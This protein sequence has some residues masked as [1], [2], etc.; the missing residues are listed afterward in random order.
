MMGT[1]GLIGSFS[2]GNLS[3]GQS[4]F[5]ILQSLSRVVQMCQCSFDV[6]TKNGM[7]PNA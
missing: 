7:S 4:P 5:R 6:E 2:D 1:A 3:G